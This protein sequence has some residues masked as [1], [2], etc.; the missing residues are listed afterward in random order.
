MDK[1][2]IITSCTEFGYLET[3]FTKD[4]RDTKNIRNMETQA[5]KII[6]TLNRGMVVKEHDKKPERDSTEALLNMS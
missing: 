1:G 2:D 6:G 4:G 3:I 5:R